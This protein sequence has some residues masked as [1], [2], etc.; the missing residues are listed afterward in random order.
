MLLE[1][2]L[3]PSQRFQKMFWFTLVAIALIAYGY[4]SGFDVKTQYKRAKFLFNTWQSIPIEK[5]IAEQF[6]VDPT[7]RRATIEYLWLNRSYRMVVPFDQNAATDMAP[8]RATLI[9]NEEES[10]DITHQPGI[11]YL[12]TAKSLGGIA[13]TVL[14]TLSGEQHRYEADQAPQYATEVLF[15]E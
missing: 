4:K 6:T 7:G 13:I 1:I 12:A 15:E 10:V 2:S 11:P 14:N 9:L 3:E 8:Y 5:T